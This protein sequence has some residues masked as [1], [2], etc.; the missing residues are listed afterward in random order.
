MSLP[1]WSL[2]S[3]WD[4]EDSPRKVPPND[5]L[6]EERKRRLRV[7]SRFR[8]LWPGNWLVGRNRVLVLCAFLV[9]GLGWMGFEYVGASGGARVPVSSVPSVSAAPEWVRDLTASEYAL[10]SRYGSP[11]YLG[12]EGIPVIELDAGVVRELTPFEMDLDSPVSRIS[13]RHGGVI[14]VSG[15]RGWGMWWLDDSE[16][17]SLRPLVS[18]DRLSWRSRQ[19]RELSRV[20][21]GIVLGMFLMNGFDLEIWESGLGDPLLELASRIK[22]P[23]PSASWGNWG[24]VPGLWVCDPALESDL[25]QGVTPGCPGVEYDDALQ[26]AWLGVGAMVDRL[27]GIGRYMRYMDGM[28][29]ADLHESNAL[30]TLSYEILDLARDTRVFEDSLARLR[31]VSREW[32]IH[33]SVDLTGRR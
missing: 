13:S 21:R 5:I 14:Q 17:A 2:P 4:E 3:I 1:R 12:A 23:Y 22:E 9:V 7:R 8:Y 31:R 25:H 32:D 18:L 29:S 26:N 6:A 33:I 10:S 30:A 16:M 19:E 11:L 27:E 28:S 20:V 24:A 15:P